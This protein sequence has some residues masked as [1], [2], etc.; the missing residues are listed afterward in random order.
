MTT[1]A[2]R[3]RSSD[4]QTFTAGA[5]AFTQA[6]EATSRPAEPRRSERQTFALSRERM[7]V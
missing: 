2:A 7:K 3:R 1:R 6:F 5:Q 4:A